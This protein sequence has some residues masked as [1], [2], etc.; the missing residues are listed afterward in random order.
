MALKDMSDVR[1]IRA[2]YVQRSGIYLSGIGL[3][4]V[5]EQA[6]VSDD[7]EDV[8]VTW[9]DGDPVGRLLWVEKST[10]QFLR[11]LSA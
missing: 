1:F 5:A 11:P 8:L 7:G 4:K 6:S 9:L 3:V 10:L 2:H